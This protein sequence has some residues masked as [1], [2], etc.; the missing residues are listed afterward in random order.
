MNNTDIALIIAVFVFGGIALRIAH[1]YGVKQKNYYEIEA[2][3]RLENDVKEIRS[4]LK[5]Y[6]IFRH[7]T[8]LGKEHAWGISNINAMKDEVMHN[9]VKSSG[10]SGDIYGYADYSLYLNKEKKEVYYVVGEKVFD[11]TE[12]ETL[13]AHNNLFK[14]PAKRQ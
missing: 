9:C 5:E 10:G 13:I 7:I 2:I 3:R 12:I 11:F 8:L 4:Q 14:L 6:E 1:M